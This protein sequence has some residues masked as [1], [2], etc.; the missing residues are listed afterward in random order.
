MAVPHFSILVSEQAK[1]YGTR[2]ALFF[3]DKTTGE[4]RPVSWNMFEQNVLQTARALFSIGVMPTKKVGIYSQNMVECVYADF[5]NYALRAVSVPM[6]A[7]AS[8]TQVRYIVNDA[9]IETIFVGEQEQ[10][11][12]VIK[13]LPEMPVLKHIIVFDNA[14]VLQKDEMSIYFDR[15]LLQGNES[16]DIK[17]EEIRR[18]A[19]AADLAIIMYTSGTTGEPKGVML[20]HA[21]FLETLLL[22]DAALPTVGEADR[23][24]SFLP[25]SHIFERAW[26]YYC[27]YRGAQIYVNQRPQE[28]Q[29]AIKEVRPTLMCSV[30]RFWEKVITGI[31]EQVDSYSPLMKGIVVWAIEIGKMY[32]LNYLRVEK[33]PP[34]WL[35][36]HYKF[37]DRVIFSK[38][39]KTLGIENATIFPVAGAALDNEI[40]TFLRSL[41]IPIVVGYGLTETTATVSFF[42]QTNYKIG[43]AGKVLQGLQVRIGDNNE[44]QV[45]GKTITQGYY[46]KPEATAAAFIDGWFRT[47]DAGALDNDGNLTVTERI[48]DLFKTTN[49]KYIAPQQIEMKLGTSKYVDQVAVIGD[50]RNYVTAIIVPVAGELLALAKQLNIPTGNIYELLTH[51]AIVQFYQTLIDDLQ[52]EM[53]SYEKIK[54]FRLINPGFT[55]EAGEITS[56][57]KL[58]RAV[59]LQHYRKLIEEMYNT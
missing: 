39:K 35:K 25:L 44:I 43:T 32:N 22:H 27:L 29:T 16:A 47:G 52:S 8:W 26:C 33:K 23:S 15:F 14:V 49:G 19:S 1:K 7:T 36:L 55:M 13:A 2:N 20:N 28:I 42:P 10:Y 57:L 24:L 17:I 38:V 9:A 12:N 46:N 41:G 21:P 56:T 48:K 54:K 31:R 45:K 58:R 4:W 59:I 34:L 50:Q 5:A 3:K 40:C 37:V 51:P 53:A 6:F 30:P 11:D 18:Q